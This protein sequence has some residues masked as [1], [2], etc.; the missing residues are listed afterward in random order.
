MTNIRYGLTI[1]QAH[2]WLCVQ[3]EEA[4]KDICLCLAHPA[5]LVIKGSGQNKAKLIQNLEFFSTIYFSRKYLSN[6]KIMLWF[7]IV[8]DTFNILF[9]FFFIPSTPTLALPSETS[10]ILNIGNCGCVKLKRGQHNWTIM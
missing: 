5:S 6:E 7:Y 8:G 3:G 2:Q 4:D 9:F 10:L 1:L